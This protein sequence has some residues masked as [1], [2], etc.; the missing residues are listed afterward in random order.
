MSSGFNIPDPERPARSWEH[1]LSTGGRELERSARRFV[2]GGQYAEQQRMLEEMA[3]R[4]GRTP[5]SLEEAFLDAGMGLPETTPENPAAS[6]DMIAQ[7]MGYGQPSAAE[8]DALAGEGVP[9]EI[10][11][12]T[13]HVPSRNVGSRRVPT[14]DDDLLRRKV[15][16]AQ[17]E[18]AQ[19]QQLNEA[20]PETEMPAMGDLAGDLGFAPDLTGEYS[21]SVGP[22]DAMPQESSYAAWGPKDATESSAWHTKAEDAAEEVLEGPI[23]P[24]IDTRTYQATGVTDDVGQ[25]AHTVDDDYNRFR[26]RHAQ[27]EENFR[28]TFGY[29]EAEAAPEEAGLAGAAGAAKL[30]MSEGIMLGALQ[31]KT[32]TGKAAGAAGFALGGTPG[33]IVG[34]SIGDFLQNFMGDLSG[35]K[36]GAALDRATSFAT[37]GGQQ[38]GGGAGQEM[39]EHVRAM[40]ANL[41]SFGN[42][43]LKI[44]NIMGAKF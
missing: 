19:Q 2:E 28:Q 8:L 30:S 41:R 12:G 21:P 37:S 38:T 29:H 11:V 27:E 4:H 34:S 7:D 23:A 40:A 35:G 6:G 26:A 36:P 24:P 1:F 16:R 43:G 15:Q 39:L 44:K 42:D 18:A 14:S 3:K 9:L 17:E 33:A 31:G 13:R 22:P 10:D 20:L 32:I 25:R 5:R